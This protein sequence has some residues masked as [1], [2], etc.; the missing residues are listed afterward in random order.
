MR[1]R[2]LICL[3]VFSIILSCFPFDARA[4]FPVDTP[5]MEAARAGDLVRV[6][7]MVEGG[8]DVNES[9]DGWGDT[10]LIAGVLSGDEKVVLYLIKKGADVNTLGAYN[11]TALTW[12]ALRCHAGIVKILID[13][14]ASLQVEPPIIATTMLDNCTR[15]PSLETSQKVDEVVTGWTRTIPKGARR[16]SR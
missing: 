16:E 15:P 3:S 13:A 2:M 11:E 14:G 5:L 1:E 4:D 10:P 6:K 9:K 12:A 7:E 8:V